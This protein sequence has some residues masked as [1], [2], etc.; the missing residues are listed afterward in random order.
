VLGPEP[1]AEAEAGP[2]PELGGG[3]GAS[4]GRGEGEGGGRDRG[5]GPGGGGGGEAVEGT[6]AGVLRH[7]PAGWTV[8]RFVGKCRR[9][10]QA[11]TPRLP[12][13]LL[14]HERL[15]EHCPGALRWGG[16]VETIG[17]CFG[18]AGIRAVTPCG[19]K[20]ATPWRSAT[21]A[22]PSWRGP[23]ATVGF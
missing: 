22:S 16:A 21:T 15:V 14:E 18:A 11:A 8:P 5:P 12:L 19:R 20:R 9:K 3:G 10:V 6:V 2:K 17:G 4:R 1:E 23:V 13:G 7:G